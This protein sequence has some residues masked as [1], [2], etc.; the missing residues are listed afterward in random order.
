MTI[1]TRPGHRPKNPMFPCMQVYGRP[2]ERPADGLSRPRFSRPTP[3]DPGLGHIRPT[4][5]PAARPRPDQA[6]ADHRPTGLVYF[7]GRPITGR[8]LKK[9][10][11]P[12][13][14]IHA[15][16]RDMP[17]SGLSGSRFF[18]PTTK[19]GR[20]GRRHATGRPGLVPYERSTTDPKGGLHASISEHE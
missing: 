5:D 12:C 1:C 7:T 10:I 14:P 8:R 19:T 9:P 6:P 17:P 2:R 13:N 11:T 16:P 15:R 4:E 3:A 18:R 20:P